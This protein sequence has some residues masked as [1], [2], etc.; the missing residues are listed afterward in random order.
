MER[1]TCVRYS[2]GGDCALYRIL[3]LWYAILA[4]GFISVRRDY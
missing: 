1:S 2:S 3:S 4:P